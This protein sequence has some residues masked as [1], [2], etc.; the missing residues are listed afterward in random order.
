MP[1]AAGFLA[2]A[3]W[4]EIAALNVRLPTAITTAAR[5]IWIRRI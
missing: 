3:V 5:I 4:P 1:P 2:A